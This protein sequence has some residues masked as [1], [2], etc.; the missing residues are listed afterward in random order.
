MRS[1]SYYI[2]DNSHIHNSSCQT[3]YINPTD[4]KNNTL[5]LRVPQPQNSVKQRKTGIKKTSKNKFNFKIYILFILIVLFSLS[6]TYILLS[7]VYGKKSVNYAIDQL[8]NVLSLNHSEYES[9]GT[10]FRTD[11]TGNLAGKIIIL[12]PGHGGFDPGCEY[13]QNSKNPSHVESKINL[14]ISLQLKK[15]LE[16]R[17][18]TVILLRNSDTFVSLYNRIATTHMYCLDYAKQTGIL[19]I[20]EENEKE[21]RQSLK[22]TIEQNQDKTISGMGI[23]AGTGVGSELNQIFEIEK[24]LSDI[25]YL[26]IHG[27]SNPQSTLRGTQ[28]YYVTDNSVAES[29]YAIPEEYTNLPELVRDPYYGRNNNANKLLAES[30]Y[31][32]ITNRVPDLITN[33]FPT[34]A[35]NYAVLREHGLTGALVEVAFLS[36]ETDRSL[37]DQQSV[38]SDIILGIVQGCE[39]YFNH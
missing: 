13:P 28:I 18:A 36:N 35:D 15:E 25:L 34:A 3:R 10:L 23:M 26:S 31:Q 27:N 14:E 4:S 5:T 12:D 20:S 24:N 9:N 29:E 21:L 7:H 17:G 32:G 1:R 33:G 30:L 16:N 22:D 19:N 8:P 39:N 2:L 6:V 37:L 11:A 38:I